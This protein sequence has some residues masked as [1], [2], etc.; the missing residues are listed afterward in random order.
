MT[1]FRGLAVGLVGLSVALAGGATAWL[2]EADAAVASTTQTA[3]G[4]QPNGV[5]FTLHSDADQTFCAEDTPSPSNPAS[6]ASMSECANRDGQHWTFADAADGSVVIIGGNTG[7]CLGFSTKAPSPVSMTP[8]TFGAAEHFFYTP[9][10][11]IKSAS[12]K[13]CLVAAAATQNAE[14]S[15]TTCKKSATLQIWV[16]GH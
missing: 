15:S 4:P 10:G 14:L 12:G 8:C 7:K 9:T 13:K 2:A 3:P 16:I 5:N 11:Q 6:G 1:S